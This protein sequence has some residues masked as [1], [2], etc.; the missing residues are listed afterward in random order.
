M[1]FKEKLIV[2]NQN[3]NSEKHVVPPRECLSRLCREARG[4]LIVSNIEN[5]M[6]RNNPEIK[7]SIV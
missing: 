7:N 1:S 5:V 4:V 2:K 6:E 3:Y